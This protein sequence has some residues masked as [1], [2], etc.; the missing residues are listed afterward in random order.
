MSGLRSYTAG[1]RAALQTLSRGSCYYPGCGEPLV[2]LVKEDYYI[3]YEIAH[4]RGAQETGARHDPNMSDA[5][6]RAFVNL[7][8][9]CLVH[10]KRVDRTHPN[11]HTPE[12]LLKWKSD[13]EARG[14]DAL[15][16]LTRLTEDGLRD[17]ITEAFGAKQD[18]IMQTLARLEDNDT[19]A[20]DLLREMIGELERF[21]QSSAL[22]DPDAAVRLYYASTYLADMD[23][24]GSAARLLSMSS[25]LEHLP[26][27]VESLQQV[28][29]RMQEMEGRY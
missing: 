1:T 16:G 5:Q 12:M 20:A 2:K 18:Q 24:A 14:Q 8:L 4:I 10:H 27:T 17:I 23:L 6:R 26:S 15:A 28:V 3:N 7:L 25:A 21:R 9:L 29:N 19:Q 11:E 13:R 22:F